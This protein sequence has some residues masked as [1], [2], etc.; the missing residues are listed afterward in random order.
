MCHWMGLHFCH[1]IDYHGVTFLPLDRLPWGYIFKRVAWMG[2]N[3]FRIL[4]KEN[5]GEK[6]F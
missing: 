1:W 2:S 4:G 3:I 6:G 5:S